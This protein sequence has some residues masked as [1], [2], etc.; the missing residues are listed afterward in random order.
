MSDPVIDATQQVWELWC[1][2]GE[3]ATEPGSNGTTNDLMRAAARKVL[4]PLREMHRPVT[5]HP[6]RAPVC[7]TCWDIDGDYHRWPCPSAL[8]LYTS[9][10]LKL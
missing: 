3:V 10:E 1:A 5:Y 6:R 9:E 8:H 2:D 7:H 4:A